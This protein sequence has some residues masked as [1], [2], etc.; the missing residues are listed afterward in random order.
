MEAHRAYNREW[1]RLNPRS[2]SPEHGAI[3]REAYKAKHPEKVK[4]QQLVRNRINKGRWPRASFFGCTDCSEQ[5]AHY[6]HE[7]YD[8][9]ASVEPLCTTCHGIRHRLPEAN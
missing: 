9:P 2:Y 6:H 5:A 4:A 3:K 8:Q 7:H 1:A